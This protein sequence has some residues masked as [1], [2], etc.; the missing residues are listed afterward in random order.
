[1]R[2]TEDAVKRI[3]DGTDTKLYTV[4]TLERTAVFSNSTGYLVCELEDLSQAIKD[5]TKI[6]DAIEKA[7][8]V[9]L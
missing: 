2:F 7:T 4:T 6:K 8:G 5:L 9:I 3:T 1:M